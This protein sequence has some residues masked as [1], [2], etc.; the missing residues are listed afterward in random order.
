MQLGSSGFATSF[1]DSSTLFFARL[2][3][4]STLF[5][6]L[7]TSCCPCLTTSFP[8]SSAL[9]FTLN[10]SC[11]PRFFACFPN[12]CTL[13]FAFNAS[14]LPGL[15]TS[16][17]KTCAVLSAGLDDACSLFLAANTDQAG[18]NF[19]SLLLREAL[20]SSS[21]LRTTDVLT[22]KELSIGAV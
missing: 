3:N 11:R 7:N 1:S 22:S 12:A 17:L 4:A 8:D 15:L 13:F 2:P 10:F 19:T 18:F 9:L 14:R 6:T 5:F 16:G 20:F 21:S